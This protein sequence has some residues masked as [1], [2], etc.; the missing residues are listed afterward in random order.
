M[1]VY[2]HSLW[3]QSNPYIYRKKIEYLH[4]NVSIYSI[5]YRYNQVKLQNTIKICP[6]KTIHDLQSS[7][8]LQCISY[9]SS[10]S[11]S[12]SGL[13]RRM[14]VGSDN[15]SS[16]GSPLSNSFILYTITTVPVLPSILSN[17][18]KNSSSVLKGEYFS[19]ISI[20]NLC[21][22]RKRREKVNKICPSSSSFI[23]H[24]SYI[25]LIH[26]K[27]FKILYKKI[28]FYKENFLFSYMQLPFLWLLHLLQVYSLYLF[29]RME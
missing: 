25:Y 3:C 18:A 7:Y 17:W 20:S 27:Y 10:E 28:C 11:K 2:K 1:Q 24:M 9:P 15:T 13:A 4:V 29:Q 6:V 26:S 23:Y 5:C 14:S 8:N 16:S 22:R 21:C 12:D 19:M